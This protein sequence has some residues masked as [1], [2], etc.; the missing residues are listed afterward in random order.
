MTKLHCLWIAAIAAIILPTTRQ[1]ANADD[2]WI[3]LFNGK[4]L[5]GWKTHPDKPG[6]WQ[7]EDGMLVSRGDGVSHLFSERGDF[8]NFHMRVEVKI[9]AKG[10][11]GVYF[12]SEHGL[13]KPAGGKTG[14]FPKGYEAQVDVGGDGETHLTGSLYGF[15]Q[16][17]D[18]L[19]A[20]DAWFTLEVIAEGKHIIIM[21][22]GKKA[23]DY[24]DDKN[25]YTKGHIALQQ[26][27]AETLVRFRKIE[28]KVAPPKQVAA[29]APA[30]PAAKKLLI[31][32]QKSHHAT[33]TPFVEHKKKLLPTEV[34]ALDAILKQTN[35][36]DDAEKLKRY[37]YNRWKADK[38]GHVLLVG[39]A[40]VMPV[41]FIAITDGAKETGGTT[42][43]SCDL[44]Y[45]DLAKK[46]GSFGDWN[47]N[48]EGINAQLYG[49]LTGFDG[50]NPINVDQID[51]LPDVA[52]GRWPVHTIP[53]LQAVIAKTI[54]Y[55]NH[56][57]A[58]DL[59][60]VRRTAFINGPNLIDLRQRMDDWGKKLEDASKWRP[61]RRYYKDGGRDDKMPPPNE[62]EVEKVLENGVGMI[63]HA[64]HGGDTC[65]DGC[66]EINRVKSLKYAYLPPVM[67][68][69]GCSTAM[70]APLP[71]SHPYVDIHGKQHQGADNKETF[72]STAPL[73]NNYQ[74][75]K[76]DK[77]SLGVE[78][79]R[80]PQNG[81]VAYIGCCVG[82][83]S[84]AWPMMEG[85]I[86]FI[87]AHDE[88]RLGDA[89][90]G[91]IVKYYDVMGIAT[92][93][94]HDWVQVAIVHQ[95]MK[96]QLFGDPSMR[97]PRN[98]KADEKECT[99]SNVAS[100]RLLDADLDTINHDGAKVQ[101]YGTDAKD[102]PNRKWKI[103]DAGNG[104]VLIVNVQSV[105][106]L[107]AD[108]D[109]INH[110]GTKVQLCGTDAKDMPNRTWKIADAG[111]G[112]VLIRNAQSGRVLDADLDTI[113]DEGTRVQLYGTDAKDMPNRRWKIV[114][115]KK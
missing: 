10:N 115:M 78:F 12:R 89:W 30:A 106:L 57:L 98:P 64:G 88:P 81:C 22:D 19:V 84:M 56:V 38:I 16:V 82:S 1:V 15:A 26:C 18:K 105:R 87:A 8:E 90:A 85:F 73:P 3:K 50:K 55:E 45:G 44:Y 47:A 71:P 25:T 60:A 27:N 70:Y 28:I 59:P 112:T 37:L 48:K 49:Q 35:G 33:L 75:G 100:G 34:V 108:R 107:H 6:K 80:C 5:T 11:S 86:E 104:T 68:S 67:F 101:L 14:S 66:L 17:K 61:V 24:V 99:I 7:V 113:K 76:F 40:E 4:D 72:N 32:A 13:N 52:L 79:V 2:G 91:A 36:A 92:I 41:R 77:T 94:A 65:W 114:E 21:V 95:G 46:D 83:Q 69:I 58:D 43:A 111:N 103:A 93:K 102:M 110:E 23:V 53:Q 62:D 51:Y 39:D 42:F 63:F 96:F 29:K 31:V 54:C 97:L 20:A 109:T 74:C 9:N